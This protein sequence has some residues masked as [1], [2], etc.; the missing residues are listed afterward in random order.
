MFALFEDLY[1]ST[2]LSPLYLH[3]NKGKNGSP[4]QSKSSWLL[5]KSLLV[6][7]WLR[8]TTQSSVQESSESSENCMGL[9]LGGTPMKKGN[10]AC[11]SNVAD[12][13][14]LQLLPQ[15]IWFLVE[16]RI[17]RFFLSWDF[18]PRYNLK[19][20]RDYLINFSKRLLVPK[21]RTFV[22]RPVKINQNSGSPI[23]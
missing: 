21:K 9:L 15:C 14:L 7:G 11:V 13:S 4:D 12:M 17:V 1:D 20:A 3:E 18:I 2:A 6:C 10:C 8:D 16:M 5:P 19:T 22:Q 23:R